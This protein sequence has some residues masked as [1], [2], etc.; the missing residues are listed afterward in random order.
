L[1]S[2]YMGLDPGQGGAVAV[3]SESREIVVLEDWPGD[4]GT[5]VV[6]FNGWR[7]LPYVELAALERV[8]AMPQTGGRLDVQ[9]RSE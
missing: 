2:L 1:E 5:L 6:I 8:N 7:W 4:E 3:I 9:V